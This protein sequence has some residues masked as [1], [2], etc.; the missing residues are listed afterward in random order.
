MTRIRLIPALVGAAVLAACSKDG[1]QS[2]AAPTTGAYIKFYNF[3]VNAPGVNFY[4]NDT[5]VTAISSTNCT[6]TP[7]PPNP[8]CSSTGAESAN[9]TVYGKVGNAGLYSS[10]AAA[11]YS[12]SGR[13]SAATDN[14]LSVAKISSTLGDGKYYSLYLSGF[15]DATAKTVDGFIIEDVFPT[16]LDFTKSNVRF[17]NASPNS[18]PLTLYAKSTVTGDSIVIGSSIAYKSGSAFVG[19]PGAV[20]NLTGRYAG[21]NTAVFS[22]GN[23]SLSALRVYTISAGGDATVTSTTAVTRPFLDVTPN[24]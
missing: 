12:F 2:I 17:V 18:S 8:A 20:Y 22:L 4:A 16:Q 15:Y 21:S 14:G 11:Q 23:V 1:V 24:R 7:V 3:G 10:I 19:V 13:I 6:P 9:G 5:K